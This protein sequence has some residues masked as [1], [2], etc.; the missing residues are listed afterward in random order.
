VKKNLFIAF[1]VCMAACTPALPV[2]LVPV[3]SYLIECVGHAYFFGKVFCAYD[4][5]GVDL[6]PDKADVYVWVLCGEYYLDDNVLT[7][8]TASSLPVALHLRGGN[9]RYV[10]TGHEVPGEGVDYGPSIQKIFPTDAIE[11]MCVTDPDCYNERAE[12]LEKAVEQK[13]RGYYGLK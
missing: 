9:D 13:A 7:L 4:V 3:E 12:R 10:V 5:L 11:K 8:G 2:Y 6:Q 1:L